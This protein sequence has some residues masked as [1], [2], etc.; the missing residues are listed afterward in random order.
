MHGHLS[1]SRPRILPRK[2]ENSWNDW[3]ALS[4][5]LRK[6]GS[7]A[8]FINWSIL[9]FG[10]QQGE[11][12]LKHNRTET[13]PYPQ[14]AEAMATAVGP[15]DNFDCQ[16]E[17]DMSLL[18]GIIGS[19]YDPKERLIGSAQMQLARSVWFTIFGSRLHGR[20]SN[21][22]VPPFC[23]RWEKH[24]RPRENCWLIPNP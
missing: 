17:V 19:N 12:D 21:G 14:M 5:S 9:F 16:K 22:T 3:K 2:A 4:S 23:I 18:G 11:V 24:G 1:R 6:T 10:Y 8:V 20:N 15:E 13:G 7:C